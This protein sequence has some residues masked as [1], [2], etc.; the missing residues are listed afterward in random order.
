MKQVAMPL[1]HK[2]PKY[3]APKGMKKVCGPSS[4]NRSQIKILACTN[5]VGT[6]VPPMVIFKGELLNYEWTRGE[7]PNIIYGMLPQGWIDHELLLIDF[8]S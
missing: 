2:Q 1:D 7:I 4:G 6:V 5:A 8:S 3:I